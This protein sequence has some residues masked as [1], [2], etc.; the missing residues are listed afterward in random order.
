MN[1]RGSSEV[2]LDGTVLLPA[3]SREQHVLCMPGTVEKSLVCA[4][5]ARLFA[6][7][8]RSPD[9]RETGRKASALNV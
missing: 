5:E 4:T 9:A 7:S 3:G 8:Q 6:S 1:L 2:S